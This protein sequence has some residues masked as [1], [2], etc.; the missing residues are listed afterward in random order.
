VKC[1]ASGEAESSPMTCEARVAPISRPAS[2]LAEASIASK[3]SS[4]SKKPRPAGRSLGTLNLHYGASA[5]PCVG[6]RL[7]SNVFWSA[8]SFT[9]IAG[10]WYLPLFIVLLPSI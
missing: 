4:M 8:M 6:R 2:S 9:V 7:G 5:A 3:I 10:W 1:R